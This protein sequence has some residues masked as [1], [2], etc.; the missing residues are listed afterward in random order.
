MNCYALAFLLFASFQIQAFGHFVWI[1]PGKDKQPLLIF[2]DQMGPD[3]VVPVSKISQTKIFQLNGNSKRI[4]MKRDGNAYR[5]LTNAKGV[6]VL[7]GI[8]E[9][10]VL[11][12]GKGEPFLLIYHPKAILGDP[13]SQQQAAADKASDKLTLQ[14]LEVSREGKQR[15]GQVLYQ[16]KPL[17]RAEVIINVPGR[18]RRIKTETSKSG[19]FTYPNP[20][21]KGLIN[22]RTRH[23]EDKD[24]THLGKKYLVIRHYATLTIPIRTAAKEASASPK[25]H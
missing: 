11:Q 25:K 10:G 21:D 9:Y 16:G 24:G 17:G 1:I 2:S 13:A 19:F 8:C 3:D 6:M 12:K 5:L 18:K 4:E 22:I 20:T 14:I 23:F 15:R 7:G